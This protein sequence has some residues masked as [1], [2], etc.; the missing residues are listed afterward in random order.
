MTP[1]EKD[2]LALRDRAIAFL[3]ARSSAAEPLSSAELSSALACDAKML[4][5]IAPLMPLGFTTH[6]GAEFKMY[7]RGF[8]RWR[9]HGQNIATKGE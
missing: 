8:R 1:S 3:R 7:G 2:R 5:K 9:W 6:D 4:T